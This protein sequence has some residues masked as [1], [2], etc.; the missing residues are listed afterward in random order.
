MQDNR[1]IANASRAIRPHE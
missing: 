1:I